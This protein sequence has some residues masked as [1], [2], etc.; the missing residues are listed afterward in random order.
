MN[1]YISL[2]FE[3]FGSD[4]VVQIGK[5]KPFRLISVF[6]LESSDYSLALS[7]DAQSDSSSVSGRTISPRL[8]SMDFE[9]ADA[10]LSCAYRDSILRFFSPKTSGILRVDYFGVKRKIAYEV[11]SFKFTHAN[12]L[13]PLRI[14]LSLICPDPYFKDNEAFSE[15]IAKIVPLI[16]FPTS[17]TQSGCAAS[18]KKFGDVVILNNSGDIPV[19]LDILFRASEEVVNPQIENLT[20]QT[21]ILVNTTLSQGDELR[22]VTVPGKKRVL[23]N[24]QN[25]SNLLDRSSSFFPLELGKNRIRFSAKSGAENLAVFPMW[26]G[27]YFGI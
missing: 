2:S 19:G 12:L 10:S 5:N 11:K 8:I 21:F 24:G 6:G 25:V 7:P 22:I 3:R 1:N 15:N 20:S 18:Y 16:A 13:D 17:V 27:A 26:E 4:S 14:N 9:L 23:K